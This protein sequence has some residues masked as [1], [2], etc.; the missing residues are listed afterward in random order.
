MN[1]RKGTNWDQSQRVRLGI[2]SSF[3][4]PLMQIL[5]ASKNWRKIG[6]AFEANAVQG[7]ENAKPP[8]VSEVTREVPEDDVPEEYLNNDKDVA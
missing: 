5:K 4:R 8:D 7:V 3:R 1:V 6:N 2:F